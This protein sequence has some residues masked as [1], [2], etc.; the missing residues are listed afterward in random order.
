MFMKV[1]LRRR[2]EEYLEHNLILSIGELK[3]QEWTR[4]QLTN[5]VRIELVSLLLVGIL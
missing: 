4:K 5:G 1:E 3:K 2:K